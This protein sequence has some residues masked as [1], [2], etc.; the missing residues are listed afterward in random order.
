[1]GNVIKYG[2]CDILVWVVVMMI[3]DEV[4]VEVG[5]SGLVIDLCMF[6]CIFDLFECGEEC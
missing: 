2:V 6:D 3:G 1:M 4:F 5:N